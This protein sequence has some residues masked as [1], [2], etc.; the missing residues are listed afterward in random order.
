M[1]E[2]GAVQIGPHGLIW[3]EESVLAAMHSMHL[4]H[5]DKFFT[6]TNAKRCSDSS[7]SLRGDEQKLGRIHRIVVQARP[8]LF[9]GSWRKAV[10][11]MF[12]T[13]PDENQ[14][15]KTYETH[16]GSTKWTRETALAAGHAAVKAHENDLDKL[17]PTVLKTNGPRRRQD[18][19]LRQLARCY[20]ATARGTKVGF[21][22]WEQF[23]NE[24]FKTHPDEK[25]HQYRYSTHILARR[26]GTTA[27][28]ARAA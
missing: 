23:S 14:R 1:P 24:V 12:A 7:G 8:D 19:S 10:N 3:T 25:Y 17:N 4:R 18:D 5:G 11:K 27:R 2:T 6:R 20:K 22:D 16:V 26:G 9:G 21:L 15:V 28:L 13:H